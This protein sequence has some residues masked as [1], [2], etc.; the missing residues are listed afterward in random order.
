MNYSS[1]CVAAGMA[2]TFA[3]GFGLAWSIRGAD[4]AGAPGR[5]TGAPL[6]HQAARTADQLSPSLP[7][8]GGG[9]ATGAP[10]S[11]EEISAKGKLARDSDQARM[12]WQEALA[13]K[14]QAD[15]A[16]LRSL[17]QRYDSER[18][19]KDRELLKSVLANVQAPEVTALVARLAASG[20]PSQ[21]QDAFASRPRPY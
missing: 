1:G 12:E 9:P 17:I 11:L 4:S 3:L 15:P 14:A 5:A 18:D 10:S 8:P 7:V 20:N 6:A 16:A 19:P 13:A 2:C 21:R